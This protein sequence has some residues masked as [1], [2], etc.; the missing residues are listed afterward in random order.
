V[1]GGDRAATIL[2]DVCLLENPLAG[3]AYL[4]ID[5]SKAAAH[6]LL[7]ETLTL[8]PGTVRVSNKLIPF[9]CGMGQSIV[10]APEKVADHIDGVIRDA[11]SPFDI[12]TEIAAESNYTNALTAASSYMFAHAVAVTGV[13]RLPG[14]V[15]ENEF[16][17]ALSL[18][19][20]RTHSPVLLYIGVFGNSISAE[21]G[22]AQVV[23]Q[24]TL[25]IIS[26]GTITIPGQA[27][28]RVLA[29]SLV[30]LRDQK[31]IT[32]N[33]LRAKGDPVKPEVVADPAALALLLRGVIFQ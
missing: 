29:A 2:I 7:R 10:N 16:R 1:F 27:D 23:G 26:E 32:S 3:A 19:S 12:S 21:L 15:S 22:I 33:A 25:G 18:I 13:A 20:E 9:V 8:L 5:E 17:K 6:A 14:E 28:G 31:V 30:D 4:T 24:A 11:R